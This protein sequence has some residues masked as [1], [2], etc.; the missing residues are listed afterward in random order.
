MTELKLSARFYTLIP[1]FIGIAIILMQLFDFLLKNGLEPFVGYDIAPNFAGWLTLVSP[2][3]VL[4]ASYIILRTYI[5]N[6]RQRTPH[7]QY[8]YLMLGSFAA[9]VIVGL[10]LGP[11]NE[12]YSFVV[13]SIAEATYLSIYGISGVSL[14]LGLARAYQVRSFTTASMLICTFIAVASFSTI[15]ELIGPWF[16][17]FG[18]GLGQSLRAGVW[19]FGTGALFVAIAAIAMLVRVV[20]LKER[21]R[22]FGG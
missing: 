18:S 16:L 10:T 11:T 20:T 2:Y 21:L 8:S 7:Y 13:K 14:A 6:V 5:R 12:Q 9:I 22:A 19:D 3:L 15:G 4:V 1:S 17:P